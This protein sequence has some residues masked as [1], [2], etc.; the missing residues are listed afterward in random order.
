MICSPL[1][2]LVDWCGSQQVQVSHSDL[3]RLACGECDR[4]ETCPAGVHGEGEEEEAF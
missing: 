4:S 1:K 2:Q 3:I